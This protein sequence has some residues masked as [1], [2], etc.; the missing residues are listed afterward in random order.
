MKAASMPLLPESSFRLCRYPELGEASHQALTV[1]REELKTNAE[2]HAWW[3]KGDMATDVP[4]IEDRLEKFYALS[5]YLG[6]EVVVLGA[7]EGKRIPS[8]CC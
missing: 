8:F 1:F 7:N 3:Q 2:L 4:K 5:Q 6:D